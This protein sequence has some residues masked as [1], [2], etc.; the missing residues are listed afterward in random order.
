MTNVRRRINIFLSVF[1]IT[2]AISFVSGLWMLVG[3]NRMVDPPQLAAGS[4]AA[5]DL[6]AMLDEAEQHLTQGNTEQ[7]LVAF[8]HIL[9]VDPGY[10]DA[11]LGLAAGELQAG[12]EDVAQSELQRVLA[13]DPANTA[14]LLESARIHSH[15]AA[16]WASAEGRYRE[17]LRLKPKDAQAWLE[18][19][20]VLS[21]RQKSAEAAQ[22]FARSDVSPLLKEKD[23]RDFAF[24]L[25][26]SGEFDRA[27]SQLKRLLERD[28]RDF[29]IRLQLASIYSSRN[30]W[31][32]A[33]PIYQALLN[34]RPDDFRLNMT[35]GLGLLSIRR[36]REA[37]GP[38][39]KA[40]N[41]QPADG[42]A[43]LGFARALKGADDLRRADREFERVL[44]QYQ[45][46]GQVIREYAD[47]LME[48][49]DYGK[50]EQYYKKAY[51]LGIRDDRLLMGLAGALSGGRKYKEALPH[52]EQVYMQR[53]SERVAF[54]LAKLYQRTGRND[55]AL[56][57]IATIE[58]RRAR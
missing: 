9:S 4:P 33:L 29:D 3:R 8:R 21:W 19:A 6:K 26:R 47:L 40:R 53:P 34:E 43:G 56:E 46:N 7:A 57:L 30:D 55:R 23:H 54:E 44:P 31:P 50:S 5:A 45:Q 11:Q 38:L 24:A 18:L 2:L 32:R 22:L 35:Y 1:G 48:R 20:R 17:Y 28:P 12:R 58:Q 13:M 10:L 41:R 51:A 37:L 16:T 25:V 36:Y 14:A 15:R 52:V 27:E 49:K 39:E 42:D